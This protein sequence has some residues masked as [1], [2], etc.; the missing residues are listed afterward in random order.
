MYSTKDFDNDVAKL[1]QLIQKC[2]QL[3]RETKNKILL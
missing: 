2:E 3:E 1:R